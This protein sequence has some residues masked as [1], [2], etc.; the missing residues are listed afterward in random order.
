MSDELKPCPLCKNKAG[1]NKTKSM[2][3][4]LHGEKYHNFVT[5][6]GNIK[7]DYK[8]NC[9]AA[10]KEY[11]AKLW[12]E[13]AEHWNARTDELAEMQAAIRELR[14]ALDMCNSFKLNDLVKSHVKNVLNKTKKWEQ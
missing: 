3:C 10:T 14:G 7:C 8:P 4:Q 9:E 11:S 12:N 6:C 5:F 1:Q 13:R 2:R